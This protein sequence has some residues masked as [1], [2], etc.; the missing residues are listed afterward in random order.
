MKIL[1]VEDDDVLADGLSY[2]LRKN[3][4][5]ISSAASCSHAEHL[6]LANDFD[7]IILD[8]SLPDRDGLSL[9]RKLRRQRNTLPVLIL[10]AR[11]KTDDRIEGFNL[12]A[13]D[14]MS[15]PFELVELEARINALY[16]RCYGGFNN[17]IQ[18]G[19]LQ[20]DTRHRQLQANGELLPLSA[21]ETDVLEI[22]LL[23][24][25]KLVGKDRISQRIASSGD[26]PLADNAIEVYIHRLRKRLTPHGVM[27][28]TLRGLGYMLETDA[29]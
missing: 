21:R 16:R 13:D 3:N 9:L 2:T 1:L 24:A 22:L 12:G 15:K 11:D 10:T 23:H 17:I 8:L 19:E 4:H 20:F 18:V 26:E 27:I 25:G 7:L 6:L 28:R 14:Y 5:Q 29:T